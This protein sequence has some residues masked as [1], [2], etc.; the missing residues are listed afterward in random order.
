MT[1]VVDEI[2]RDRTARG[3]VTGNRRRVAEVLAEVVRE[4]HPLEVVAE[5]AKEALTMSV[6]SIA[7]TMNAGK[8]TQTPKRP[9]NWL[10]RTDGD[11]ATRTIDDW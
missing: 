10:V 8:I 4:G 1:A 5:A 2:I 3:L 11:W 6:P 9:S 7:V